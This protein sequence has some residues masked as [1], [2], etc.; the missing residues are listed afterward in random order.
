MRALI[1]SGFTDLKDRKNWALSEKISALFNPKSKVDFI[2]Q[3]KKINLFNK[4]ELG[5]FV[6]HESLHIPYEKA[7][8]RKV[9][10]RTGSWNLSTHFPWIGART[11]SPHGP[12]VDFSASIQNPIGIKIP[13]MPLEKIPF[14]IEK[15]K[16][17]LNPNNT[18]GRLTFIH[19][20]GLTK[21]EQALPVLLKAIKET[22]PETTLVCDPMHGNTLTKSNG[23]KERKFE[24]ICKELGSAFSIHNEHG[25]PLNGISIELTGDFVSECTG[26]KLA[27]KAGPQSR[28]ACDPRLNPQQALELAFFVGQKLKDSPRL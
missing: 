16:K 5:F 6:S 17:A 24:V 20:F 27:A 2:T 4:E 26:G 25:M 9:P 13:P 12:H 21:I 10:R 7:L 1:D 23:W 22:C 8:T 19:R 14:H 3:Q 18:R 11:S 15:L 28:S